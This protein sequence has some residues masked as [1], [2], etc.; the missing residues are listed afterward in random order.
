MFL[1]S[2]YCHRCVGISGSIRVHGIKDS[3][4]VSG[5]CLQGHPK[6]YGTCPSLVLWPRVTNKHSTLFHARNKYPLRFPS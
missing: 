2:C 3:V 6:G 1:F 4:N 5:D